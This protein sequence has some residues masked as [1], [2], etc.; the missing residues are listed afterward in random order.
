MNEDFDKFEQEVRGYIYSRLAKLAAVIGFLVG[1][2]LVFMAHAGMNKPITADTEVKIKGLV[3][4]ICGYGLVKLFRKDIVVV[5]A[6]ID[7]Q[8]NLLLLDF[9]ESEDG[10]VHYIKNDRI[11]KMVTDSGYE[12]ESIK[13]LDNKKP[14]RYNKP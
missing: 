9:L 5:D 14:N 2:G 4:S 12:V 8:K 3:C 10:V 7:I 13:R 6:V 11:I 1:V